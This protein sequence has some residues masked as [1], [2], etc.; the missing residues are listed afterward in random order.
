MRRFLELIEQKE[1][2]VFTF[3]RFNP[4]TTGHEKLIQKVASVAGSNP[5]RIYPS[6][7]QNQKKD[8]LPFTLKIAYMRK[9]YPRF[10]KNII[11]DKDARTAINIAVKL[12]DEGFKN[13]TM[14]VGSDRVREFS[15]LLNNYNGV[16][17]KRHGFYK[18]DKINVVSAGERDPDAEGVE[19][20]SASKMRKAASDSDFDS[21]SQGLPRNFKDGK[22]LYLDVRKHMGIR[23]ERDMGE[24]T[25]FESLRDMYLTGK[26][27]NIDDMVEANGVQGKIIR[28]GTNYVA[29]NDN[30]GKVHKVWLHEINLNEIQK[31]LRRVKQD[32]DIKGDKGTEP[33]KYYKGVAR[34]TKPKRDDHFERGAK[35]DDDNPAAYTPAPGDKDKSGKL[36]KTKP[37]K[38]TLKF[39]KMFGDDVNEIAPL[40]GLGLR[41]APTIAK[42]VSKINPSSVGSGAAA[43]ATAVDKVKQKLTT[44]KKTNE[45][46]E[47][48]LG[49]RKLSKVQQDRLDDLESY[50]G[51]LQRVSMTPQ[52]KLEIDA[53]KRKIEKLKSEY[54]PIDESWSIDE[55][56]GI[57]VPELIKT[58]IHRLTHP[59]GYKD[60]ITKYIERVKQTRG[61]PSNGAIL[62]DLGRQMGF[63]RIKPLQMYV[64][65][66]VQKGNL[67]QELAADYDHDIEKKDND[68]E[69][70]FQLDE[71]IE[72]LVKKSK[73]SGVPY[74]ILKQVYSRGMAAWRTGHRPGTTP[75]QWAFARVNSFLTGGGAR[76]ADADLW[77]KASAAKKAKKEE[78]E[79]D[80]K[81]TKKD[82]QDNENSNSHTE[83]GVKLVN[84][85]GTPAEK[86]LMGQIAK[87]HNK[88]GSI[89][90]KE[91]DLRDKLVKKYYPKLESVDL[92]EKYDLYHSTFSGAMQHAYD[93]AKKKMG[94]T[95]DSKDIDSKVATGPKK[96]SEGKTNKYR[97]KGKGGNLQIQVYN[98][99]GSK[100]FELNMYKEEF[101]EESVQT[102]YES[103]DTRMKYQLDHG[104]D[105][106]WKMNEVHDKMLEKLGL[107]EGC[108]IDGDETPKV[109]MTMKEFALKNA[110]GEIDEGAEYDGRPVKLNNPT[111]GDRK[112]YKVYVKNDKGNVVK[113]EFGDPNMSIKRDDPAR[114]KSFRARHNCDNPG[115]KYKARY[116]SC[117]F[118]STKSVT[119]LMKG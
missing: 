76:K 106:W 2:V 96:P 87:N 50:L 71:K 81:F 22:K 92:D 80:E 112:K 38:H 90:K 105:W 3:G 44:K 36:K 60:L 20:M 115:P 66:L 4:P 27:W 7:S 61:K 94:I 18:F 15:S 32:P 108:S 82:F 63:D 48:E 104:D 113:V 111:R 57:N 95:V 101:T 79:L 102:W 19:G 33:A 65:K 100:P 21:F 68:M 114:R 84:M 70:D 1:N 6:Y 77:S 118:W 109:R 83:N 55:M 74:G 5:F 24:M 103:I 53:T 117:K 16:E 26:I 25:D 11:A 34:K 31:G 17:G 99:G 97:L 46:I 107:D 49:E 52:R 91:Q 69:E 37:S 23:E 54:D 75:Q 119:D 12:H 98:K 10:A 35:M 42:Y 13:V 59:K 30:N 56:T 40:V 88:Q 28:K 116:W 45:T 47:D 72:G 67:P 78:F 89:E 39:K 64:N 93:Y 86:K 9:M 41:A 58:T 29:F 85:Y 62:S 14:V 51:H 8:P 43:V 73:K 110:W